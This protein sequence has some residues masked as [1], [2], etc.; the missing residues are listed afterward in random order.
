[1]QPALNLP[2]LREIGDYPHNRRIIDIEDMFELDDKEIWGGRRFNGDGGIDDQ[3]FVLSTFPSALDW[4][5]VEA[6]VKYQVDRLFI[7][8]GELFH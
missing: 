6:F 4:E 5:D 1:M 7:Y 3:T 2:G 8:D